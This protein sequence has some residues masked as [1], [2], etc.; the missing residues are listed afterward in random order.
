MKSEFKNSKKKDVCE[1]SSTIPTA[2]IQSLVDNYRDNQLLC[3]NENLS[4]NDAHS[5]WFNMEILN[6]FIAEIKAKAQEVDPN[7]TDADL[8]I[9]FYYAAYPE[10]PEST[11][12]SNY[13]RRHTLVLVP[14]KKHESTICDFNPYSPETALALAQNH[15]CLVPPDNNQI[16][17]Y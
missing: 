16:E 1:T 4:M 7:I 2:Q 12:P 14:T 13:G 15:G 6:N 3:I 5:I 10:V 8:G 17:S 11:T 9:R